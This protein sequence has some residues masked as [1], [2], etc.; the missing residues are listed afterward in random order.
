MTAPAAAIVVRPTAA[1]ARACVQ[2]PALFASTDVVDHTRA[3]RLCAVCPVLAHCG[4]ATT[5][6]AEH[7][8]DLLHGTYAGRRFG[9]A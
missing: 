2:D 3:A 7:R 8:P 1:R 4:E 9:G 6:T 5:Q